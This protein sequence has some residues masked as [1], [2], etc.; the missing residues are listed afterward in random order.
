VSLL[1]REAFHVSYQMCSGD[2]TLS[3]PLTS[4]NDPGG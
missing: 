1:G 2:P 4:E 3:A